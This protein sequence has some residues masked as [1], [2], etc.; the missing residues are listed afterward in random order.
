MERKYKTSHQGIA[1]YLFLK[2][3]EILRTE[4]GKSKTGKPCVFMEFNCDQTTGRQMGDTFF[5]GE[6]IG[7]LKEYNEATFQIR[8]I[9]YEAR[10]AT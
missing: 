9:V 10:N 4:M 7:N 3:F 2:G 1:A 6:A 8:Q 5:D